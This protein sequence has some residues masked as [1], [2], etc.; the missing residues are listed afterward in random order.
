MPPG[1]CCRCW[2]AFSAAPSAP[3]FWTGSTSWSSSL[4]MATFTWSSTRAPLGRLRLAGE[5]ETALARSTQNANR[6]YSMRYT[7]LASGIMNMP[8]AAGEGGHNCFENGRVERVR[9]RA[10]SGIVQ[11]SRR[12]F[13]RR[14]AGEVG[15]HTRRMGIMTGTV[16]VCCARESTSDMGIR[17]RLM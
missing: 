1:S 6:E 9:R 10:F 12:V 2:P 13:S 3:L 8:N 15:G 14:P 7:I 11:Y 17:G 4:S 5:R 16:E